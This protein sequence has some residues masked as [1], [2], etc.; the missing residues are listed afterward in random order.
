MQ[1]TCLV[2]YRRPDVPA[3]GPVRKGPVRMWEDGNLADVDDGPE[4][5][6]GGR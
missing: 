1:T 5:G 4:V 2:L 3:G 6:Q